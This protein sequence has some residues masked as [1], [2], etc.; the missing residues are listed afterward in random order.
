VDALTHALLGA[1]A[2]YAAR[3]RADPLELNQRLS[4]G[5]LA[6]AFPDVDFAGFLLDPLAFLADWHQAPTHS[7]VLL[8]LRAMLAGGVFA[9][10]VRRASAFPTAALVSALAIATHIASDVI[11]V[12]GTALFHP[13]SD[14][15]ASL[16][17]TFVIDP[18]FTLLVLAGLTA[19]LASRRPVVA[20][21]GLAVLAG[22]VIGQW[23]L[24]QHALDVGATSLAARGVSAER[25]SALP[26]PFSPFNWK[27]VAEDGDVYHEAYVNVAGH[28]PFVPLPVPAAIDA[29]ARSYQR[30]QAL[31]WRSRHRFGESAE[32]RD[33][34][35]RL[36]QQASFAPFRRFALFPAVSRIDSDAGETCVWF[37]DL[38]YDLPVLPDTFR[39]GFCRGGPGESW[40][41]YRL[42]YF[43]ERTRQRIG[44]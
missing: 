30:P 5:A 4:L 44:S 17:T 33:M 36:W 40:Q 6:G 26:Q 18:V 42:R 1:E 3:P 25:L 29:M 12:Y 7:L 11:T 8:P 37:T 15:R 9:A 23:Y 41:L 24:K 10:V 27:L 2:A 22:Y 32:R 21:L 38:R 28:A 19:G 13:L 14:Q 35:G 31:V 20:S 34:A 16:G 43:T 39:D